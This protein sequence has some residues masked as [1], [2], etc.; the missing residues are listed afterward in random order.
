MEK[1]IKELAGVLIDSDSRQVVP[2][3]VLAEKRAD[4]WSSYHALK[5]LIGC[6]LVGCAC[7]ADNIGGGRFA[8]D[9]W[10]DDEFAFRLEADGTAAGFR[11]AGYTIVG[12]A[13]ILGCDLETGETVGLNEMGLGAAFADFLVDHTAKNVK[14]G[15]V[16]DEIPFNPAFQ[17]V[18]LA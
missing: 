9:M 6:H 2:V 17:V 16:G 18:E 10:H 15:V 1:N 13:V 8:L 3:V 5:E 14:F 7:V 11:L 4:G 12:R